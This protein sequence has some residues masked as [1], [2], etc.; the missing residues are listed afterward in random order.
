MLNKRANILFEDKRWKDL[1]V[2]AR[3][4][5]TSVG[6]LIRNAVNNSYFNDAFAL[7]R[8]QAWKDILATRKIFKGKFNYEEY[9]NYGREH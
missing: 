7:Q 3:V 2:L 6:E 5:G 9:I 4:R 1:L 8:S